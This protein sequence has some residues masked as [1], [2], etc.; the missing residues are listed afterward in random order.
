MTNDSENLTRLDE[1]VKILQNQQHELD[2]RID[3]VLAAH[4]EDLQ[5]L[6]VLET[7]AARCVIETKGGQCLA[8]DIHTLEAAVV[9]LDRRVGALETA[10]GQSQDRWKQLL[11]FVVQLA[12]VVLAAWL[13]TKLN[14]AGVNIPG[15]P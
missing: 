13:L 14:L 1:R 5:K 3:H 12:W 2:Q 8:D 6:A 9:S 4:A 15:G 7:K 11:S 10:S